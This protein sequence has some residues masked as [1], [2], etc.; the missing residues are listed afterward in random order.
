MV[1]VDK[2]TMW[3]IPIVLILATG[4]P[5]ALAVHT[6]A[7]FYGFG[8][9]K[10]AGLRGFYDVM[11]DCSNRPYL[12]TNVTG[13]I[14]HFTSVQEVNDCDSGYDDGWNRYCHIGLAKHP[15]SAASCTGI[16]G[17]KTEIESLNTS[18]TLP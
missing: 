9:G 4:I 5:T 14:K 15:D 8:L 13:A 1:Y 12:P 7:Y 2:K 3:T 18:G 10:N 6:P 11:N 16:A 17:P